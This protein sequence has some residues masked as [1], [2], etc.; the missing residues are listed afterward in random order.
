MFGNEFFKNKSTEAKTVFNGPLST[1]GTS[2]F[3]LKIS[4]NPDVSGKLTALFQTRIFEPS[5]DF[6]TTIEKITYHPLL[7]Q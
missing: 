5:G 3:S 7:R 2:T 6:S 1:L 4:E